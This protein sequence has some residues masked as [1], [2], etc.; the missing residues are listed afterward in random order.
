MKV[1]VKIFV[2]VVAISLAIGGVMVYAKTKVAPP[3]AAKSIDQFAKSLSDGIA[4]FNEATTS[5]QED[6]LFVALTEK[7][8][9]YVSEGKLT[10]AKGN[11]DMNQLGAKYVSLFLNRAMGKFTHSTWYDSDHSY[12]LSVTKKLRSLKN[13]EN[14]QVLSRQ[15]LDSLALVEKIISDY[16]QARATSRHTTYT[17]TSNAQATISKA[18]QFAKDP[19]LAHCTDLVN[20]LNGV[21]PAIAASHYNHVCAMVENL[22]QYKYFSQ[23]YYDDTLVPQ[24]DAVVTEYDKKAS[25][26]YGTKRDVNALWNR[27]RSY[28]S[29]ASEYYNN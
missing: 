27:A 25:A 29:S 28:Y 8:K 17:G 4:M 9:F 23:S 19:Y 16:K 11:E 15:S 6:S 21:R 18:R 1:T 5:A 14:A 24:V 3:L 20:A 26:L 10:K 13:F 22:S 12:M 7:A 2:L